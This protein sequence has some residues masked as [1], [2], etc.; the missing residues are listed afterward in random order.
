V[1][2]GCHGICRQLLHSWQCKNLAKAVTWPGIGIKH[3]GPLEHWEQ[4]LR[5]EPIN[6]V[7]FQALK[8][9]S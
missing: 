8:D 9:P 2:Q 1:H 4:L 6:A 7:D 5:G 3:D